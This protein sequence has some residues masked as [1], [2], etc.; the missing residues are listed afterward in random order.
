MPDSKR[1]DW[2][3]SAKAIGIFL[4]IIGHIMISPRLRGLIFSFHMPLF[5]F[6][7]GLLFS[8]KKPF[9]DFLLSKSKSLLIPYVAFSIIS[10]ILVKLLINQQ[11]NNFVSTMI[12]SKRNQIPY[13]DPLWFLTSLFVVEIIFYFIAKYL[14]NKYAILIFTLMVGYFSTV[15]LA[16][17]SAT[18]ILPWSLDQSLLY[19]SFFGFG[20][21]LKQCGILNKDLKKSLTLIILSV[22][23]IVLVFNSTIYPKAWSLIKL[24]IDLSFIEFYIWAVL[25]IAFT[26]YISQWVSCLKWIN[27]YGKNTIPIF[28]LHGCLGFNLYNLFFAVKINPHFHNANILGVVITVFCLII[29]TPVI[30]FINKYI[31]FILGKNLNLIRR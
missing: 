25:S 18:N 21:F 24:P 31:P 2:I 23:Y 15:K 29:L 11:T 19:I 10:V 14:K 13:D 1:I 17:L 9:K 26:L 4:V 6:I 5:Y 7:S 27:F 3:D 12:L 28:T 20:Y 16:A 8:I 22:I 30:L